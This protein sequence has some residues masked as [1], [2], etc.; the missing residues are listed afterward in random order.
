MMRRLAAAMF[1][2]LAQ[3]AS[4][5]PTRLVIATVDNGHMVQLRQLSAEFESAHPDIRLSWV[6]LE[7]TALRRYVAADLASRNARFD[8]VT[9]GPY[10]TG[11]WARRG[12]LRPIRTGPGYDL[13][14]LLPTIRAGLSEGGRLYA[15]P[16]YGESSMLM[17]RKD[18]LRRAG[19]AMPAAPTWRDV[20]AMA[21]RLHDPALRIN[22]I[23]LRGKPGW[24]ANMTLVSTMV[25]AYGGQ[26]F[27]MAWQPRLDS[28]AWQEAA[29]LYVSLLRGA[30]P[31]D[32]ALRGYNDNLKLFQDGR[33][34]LWVDATVAA[35]F[36][37]DPRLSRHGADVGFAPA[38]VAHTAKG[39]SWLWSW[40]LA[41]PY[42]VDGPRE[43]AAQRFVEWSSSRAYVRLV[44]AR[45][46]W[47]MV[48]SGTRWS[49]YAE[50]AFRRAAPWADQEL[51]AIRRADPRDPTLPRSPYTGVQYVATPGFRELGDEVGGHLAQAVL[52]RIGVQEAL[53][54]AQSSARRQLA[55]E[56][57]RTGR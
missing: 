4:A 48:P 12:W 42:Y 51:A 13:D 15:A 38:P 44:A 14:D 31:A 19:L 24:G 54:R 1:G 18:L 5:A 9:I 40:A 20:A 26:W 45:K 2:L 3:L 22:G 21:V 16:L 55:P 10:E 27:D 8:V 35:P 7:E 32:A 6:I 46:G 23:C 43:A 50:P 29:G 39:S 30:G 37:S 49:T 53:Q 28:Q 34:A 52:G 11:M 41:I 17:Y 47:G 33:C 57:N 25:N 56:G 36:V